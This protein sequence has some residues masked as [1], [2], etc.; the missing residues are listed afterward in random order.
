MKNGGDGISNDGVD[1]NNKDTADIISN[2]G[3]DGIEM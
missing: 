2:D 3:C 1:H